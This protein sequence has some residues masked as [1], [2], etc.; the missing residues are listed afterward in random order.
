MILIN[1]CFKSISDDIDD[2]SKKLH[3]QTAVSIFAFQIV[4]IPINKKKYI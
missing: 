1:F 4:E 2:D 3:Q